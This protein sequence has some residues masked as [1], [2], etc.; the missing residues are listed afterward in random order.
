M[1]VMMY[2]YGEPDDED[3]YFLNGLPALS[4]IVVWFMFTVGLEQSM[5]AT[6]ANKVLNLRPAPKSDVRSVLTFGQSLKRDLLDMID[7]WGLGGIYSIIL[8]KNTE[9]NQ[10]LGDL[11]AMTVVIDTSDPEQGLQHH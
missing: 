6:I 3:G 9:Y 7:L 8:I 11:W 2:F 5:G 4:V 10:R 1:R